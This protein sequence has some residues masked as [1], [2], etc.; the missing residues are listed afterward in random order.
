MKGFYQIDSVFMIYCEFRWNFSVGKHQNRSAI[1]RLDSKFQMTGTDC[2]KE[3]V[4]QNTRKHTQCWA[5][6]DAGSQEICKTSF[7]A[8]QH[9]SI[10]SIR[11]NLH[12]KLK[13][14]QLFMRP[15]KPGRLSSLVSKIFLDDSV[16]CSF[17]K[18]YCDNNFFHDTVIADYYLNAL[19]E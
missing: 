3:E 14:S 6:V 11:D 16:V 17:S 12:T 19:Q 13:C 2:N 8:T 5:G 7:S 4:C 1:N 9:G 10:I 18:W 15:I